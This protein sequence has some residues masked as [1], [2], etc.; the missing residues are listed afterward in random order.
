MGIHKFDFIDFC[1]EV[2]DQM[3]QP[4]V[5]TYDDLIEDQHRDHIEDVMRGFTDSELYEFLDAAPP[6][7]VEWEIAIDWFGSSKLRELGLME[8]V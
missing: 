1:D 6:H 5:V 8:D 4:K 2:A 3:A 7:S